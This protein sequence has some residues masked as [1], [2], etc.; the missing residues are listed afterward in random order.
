MNVCKRVLN[1]SLPFRG[2]SARNRGCT[3]PPRPR[4]PVIRRIK[5]ATATQQRNNDVVEG[6]ECDRQGGTLGSDFGYAPSPPQKLPPR[7]DGG[8]VCT[9]ARCVSPAA[10]RAQGRRIIPCVGSSKVRASSVAALDRFDALAR[11]PSSASTATG[12]SS[13]SESLASG[14]QFRSSFSR[15]SSKCSGQRSSCNVVSVTSSPAHA[16]PI[17]PVVGYFSE[18]QLRCGRVRPRPSPLGM[19]CF[20]ES[21]LRCGRNRPQPAPLR[22]P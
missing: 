15:S 10:L 17:K 9:A 22:L 11:S 3:A 18:S 21:E 20:S 12:T 5:V 8:N 2:V 4:S 16:Q 7:L 13:L 14:E 19:G 1:L 6:F